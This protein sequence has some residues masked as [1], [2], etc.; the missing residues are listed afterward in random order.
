MAC[1]RIKLA[2][3][4]KIAA[5][6]VLLP[7]F[8]HAVNWDIQIVGADTGAISG[9][10]VDMVL[11]I[12]GVAHVVYF[13]DDGGLRLVYAC[14]EQNQWDYTT[15]ED[16][17]EINDPKTVIAVDSQG[18]VY[19]VHHDNGGNL[20]FRKK[21]NDTWSSDIF[22]LP[23]S[24]P[25][26]AEVDNEGRLNVVYTYAPGG[27]DNDAFLMLYTG[28]DYDEIENHG[29]FRS[30]S[31][32]IDSLSNP[33]LCYYDALNDVL[34]YAVKDG[35]SWTIETVDGNI[36]DVPSYV[37]GS[38][39]IALDSNDVPHISYLDFTNTDLKYA[40]RLSGNWATQ[41]V[42]DTA[43]IGQQT[44]IVV[45][46]NDAIHIFYQHF[47][48]GRVFL[49]HT[50]GTAAGGWQFADTITDFNKNSNPVYLS[51]ACDDDDRSHVCYIAPVLQTVEYA[52]PLI[53]GDPDHPFPDGDA[54][55]N[56]KVD[57][58][59]LSLLGQYWFDPGCTFP[60]YCNGADLD[61]SGAV[62]NNDLDFLV[63]NWL[64]CTL[65]D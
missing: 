61:T 17:L 56:C 44:S 47:I 19:V 48:D 60:D 55:K 40:N 25:C 6:A 4:Y 16:N 28:G 51:L 58:F 1:T 41:I 53:C 45:D 54:D 59:D 29:N 34:K 33:H 42:D 38:A 63:E 23:K 5:V 12:N 3:L 36:G 49:K 7:C 27:I 32:A 52:V 46:S 57:F 22:S 14:N 26:D 24:I 8:S 39:S 35:S 64:E 62:D 9:A 13:D 15:V 21:E 37:W 31:L 18:L 65:T 50:V 30:A 10:S 20:V 11:D 2:C 43:Y